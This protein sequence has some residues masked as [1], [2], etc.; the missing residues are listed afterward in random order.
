MIQKAVILA[1]GLG[2]R[3][4]DAAGETPK[5]LLPIEGPDGRITF[6]DWHLRCLAAHGVQEVYLVGNRRTFGTRLS[7]PNNRVRAEWILNPTEDL[8]TSGSAHSAWFAWQSE[9]R[10]LDGSSRVLMMDADIVYEPAALEV[11][12]NANR[13]RS[14][15]LVAPTFRNTAEEVLVFG[16]NGVPVRH[17][18]G[19]IGTPL[20]AGLQCLGEATGIL[21]WEPG[22]HER[23]SA[24][25]DW[26]IQHSIARTR[27]EH[28][29]ITQRMMSMNTMSAVILEPDHLFMEVDTPQDYE[30]LVTEMFPRMVARIDRWP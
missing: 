3:I 28:E 21:L 17:G 4:S 10:I 20:V 8:S 11:L 7:S 1:A 14:K 2:E 23:L 6:L 24:A 5:P 19:L 15:T 27:S 26:A 16:R 25:T 29:D 12:D 18:K 22:D 30:D 9:H 13:G